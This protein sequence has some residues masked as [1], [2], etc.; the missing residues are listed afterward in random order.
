MLLL[1]TCISYVWIITTF[2]RSIVNSPAVQT[3]PLKKWDSF[4]YP[5]H[6]LILSCVMLKQDFVS[7]MTDGCDKFYTF[8][9]KN[10]SVIHQINKISLSETKLKNKTIFFNE[11]PPPI[12]RWL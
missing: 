9:V 7:M 3:G 6:L 12:L 5:G 1:I 2:T 4:A 8:K 11:L 10:K